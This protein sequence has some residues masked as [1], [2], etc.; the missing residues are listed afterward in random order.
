MLYYCT[1]FDFNYI[2]KGIALYLSIE[3]YT[4]DFVLYIMAMDKKC[5]ALLKTINLKNVVEECIDCIESA[6]SDLNGFEGFLAGNVIKYVFRFKR[7]NGKDDL[8]KLNGI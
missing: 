3:R 6:V 1:L 7:K 2:N 4:S 5:F 8:Q